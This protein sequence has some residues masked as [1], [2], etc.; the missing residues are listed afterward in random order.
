MAIVASSWTLRGGWRLALAAKWR[1]LTGI[2][3]IRRIAVIVTVIV[4]SWRSWGGGTSFAG[5]GRGRGHGCGLFQVLQ[6][7]LTG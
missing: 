5:L 4:E 1:S 3:Y 7:R 2:R 6:H